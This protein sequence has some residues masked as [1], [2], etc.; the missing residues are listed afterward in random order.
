MNLILYT[1]AFVGYGEECDNTVLALTYNEWL[2][3]VAPRRGDLFRLGSRRLQDRVHRA[4]GGS[5]NSCKSEQGNPT[6]GRG[7]RV[8]RTLSPRYPLPNRIRLPRGQVLRDAHIV[9]GREILR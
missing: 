1:L 8:S 4:P 5:I 2:G 9:G 7:R 3:K 6:L